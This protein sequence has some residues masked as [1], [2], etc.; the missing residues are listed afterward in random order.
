MGFRQGPWDIP[1]P[2][3]LLVYEAWPW[4]S[5]DLVPDR[6]WVSQVNRGTR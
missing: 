2:L 6:D 1:R 3:P 4:M 5:G